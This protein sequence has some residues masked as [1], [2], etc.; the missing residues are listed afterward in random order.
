MVR[1]MA[2]D[3]MLLLLLASRSGR[4]TL[5]QD[6]AFFGRSDLSIWNPPLAFRPTIRTTSR[7]S[8]CH[9][10]TDSRL[11]DQ[12]RTRTIGA[13]LLGVNFCSLRLI[14]TRTALFPLLFFL[15]PQPS[16]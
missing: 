2:P 9:Q 12:N 11:V 16:P 10:D 7:A 8:V 1:A 15:G 6:S 13:F 14:E 4:G 3:S 5:G